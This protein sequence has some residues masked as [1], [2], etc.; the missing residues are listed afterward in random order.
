MQGRLLPP[1]NGFFQAFPRQKWRDEFVHA[2]AAGISNIEWIFDC[3][4][5]DVNPIS[6]KNG[7][8]QINELS[9]KHGVT[10]VSLCADYFMD[11]PLL[12]VNKIELSENINT[13]QWLI[14]QCNKAGINRIV[15]PF[16]DNSAINSPEEQIDVAIT[17]NS[18]VPFLEKSKVE[19]H[20]ETN[21]NPENFEHFLQ[22]LPHPLFKVNYDSGNS[23][24]LG[25]DTNEEFNSYGYRIGSIHIKDRLLKAGTVPLGT[26]N[27]KFDLL[28]KKI[29][30]IKYKGDFIL[31]VARGKPGDEVNWTKEN[32]N[33]I[34]NY[35]QLLN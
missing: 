22:L 4:G 14:N 34:K 32:I 24:S 16:V 11:K 27:A 30:E 23:A 19:I 3:Y 2:E 31:Q 20:L 9:Q 1:E 28:F 12:R 33:F 17:L 26:G 15:L 8:K 6:E 13:L 5:K 21:L 18:I 7:R 35:I 29:K 10:V 25:Y